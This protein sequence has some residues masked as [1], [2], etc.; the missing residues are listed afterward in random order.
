MPHEQNQELFNDLDE[1]CVMIIDSEAWHARAS[2]ECRSL[3]V[4]GW[5]KWHE[6]E[7]MLHK[8]CLDKLTKMLQSK[9]DFSPELNLER[10]KKINQFEINNLDDFIRHHSEWVEREERF[11]E[12]LRPSLKAS[13]K[14]NRELHEQLEKLEEEAQHQVYLVKKVYKR[15]KFAG[16]MP[17]DIGVCSKWMEDYFDYEYN[18]GDKIKFNIG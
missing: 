13:K 14:I 5:S 11:N 2:N 10:L 9:M 15:I 6:K 16:F 1:I 17:H 8:K 7:S 4:I 3:G 12:A 18:P